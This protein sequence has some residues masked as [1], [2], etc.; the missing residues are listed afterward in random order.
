MFVKDL[1]IWYKK[2]Q[3]KGQHIDLAL[4]PDIINKK[5]EYKVEEVQNHKKQGHSM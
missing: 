2:S 3:F 4:P 5:E 1:L